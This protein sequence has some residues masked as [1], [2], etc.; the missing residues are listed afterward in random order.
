MYDPFQN[1]CNDENEENNNDD[2]NKNDNNGDDNNEMDQQT[3]ND[4]AGLDFGA[5]LADVEK[6]TA[7]MVEMS[8][9]TEQQR[10]SA[11]YIRNAYGDDDEDNEGDD[12]LKNPGRGGD[13]DDGEDGGGG[14]TPI[15]GDY[16][17]D[18]GYDEHGI[19]NEL[20]NVSDLPERE[21]YSKRCGM[22]GVLI[23]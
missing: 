14:F 22:C 23:P 20:D 13:G 21:K 5:L 9:E 17:D 18:G 2:D 7:A 1:P 6:E 11:A 12:E 3:I 8:Q 4:L 10:T 15:G 16:D 19:C